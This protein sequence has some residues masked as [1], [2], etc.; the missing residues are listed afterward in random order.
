MT[1]SQSVKEEI[2]KKPIKD[3]CCK[4]A[5]L[6]GVLRGNGNLFYGDD[7][8]GVDFTVKSD[9]AMSLISECFSVVYGYDIRD[10]SVFEDK[11]N[12]SDVF[13]LSIRGSAAE[14]I[15]LDL[16]VLVKDGDEYAVSLKIFSK[17]TEKDCCLRSFFKG[18][19]LSSG[20]CTV[21]EKNASKNTRYHLEMEFSHSATAGDVSATL[22]KCGIASAIVR[23]KNS[24][25]VYLKGGEEMKNFF[26]FIGAPVSALKLSELMV[27]GE[28]TN[29]INRRKNCDLGNVSRQMEAAEKQISAI[30]FIEKTVGLDYLKKP[31]LI[32]TAT[33][34]RDN[35]ADSV[36]ELAEK[37]IESKSCVNHRLKKICDVADSLKTIT[38]EVK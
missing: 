20:R 7:G 24:Y 25:V 38:K 22:F 3:D 10:V 29:M 27:N 31:E 2:V 23:R 16:G 8:F 37:L 13:L 19:Y 36:G 12:K 6:L 28:L 17:I 18:L 30:D 14:R 9:G 4:K 1:F 15:L 11:L 34:R 26:A 35:P 5:F 32:K 33:L 21:P